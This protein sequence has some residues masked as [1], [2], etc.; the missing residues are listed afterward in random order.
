MVTAAHTVRL[1]ERDE[2]IFREHFACFRITTVEALQ[3]AYW[4]DRTVDAAKKWTQRMRLGRYL[5]AGALGDGRRFLYPTST[6]AAQAGLPRRIARPP[7]GYDLARLYGVLSFCCLGE[8]RYEKISSVEFHRRFEH[9][10]AKNLDQSLYYVDTDFPDGR[11]P[12]RNRIGYLLI[13]AGARARQVVSRF[14]HVVSQRL[15]VPLW[16]QWIELG[17]FIVTVVTADPDKQRQ[18]REALAA[19]RQPVPFR[20]EVRDDLRDVVPLRLTHAS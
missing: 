11:S 1:T 12:A 9:L 17:R 5:L 2:Q 13:D 18:L 16:H 6:M 8:A 20:V 7:K 4:S 15:N 3:R 14:R 19:V 10:C